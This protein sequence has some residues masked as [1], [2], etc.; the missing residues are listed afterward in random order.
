MGNTHFDDIDEKRKKNVKKRFGI[1]KK[2]RA[3]RMKARG[4]NVV[5]KKKNCN[6][7]RKKK[8]EICNTMNV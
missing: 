1:K 2:N 6:I 5:V 7:I 4:R 3:T 8:T